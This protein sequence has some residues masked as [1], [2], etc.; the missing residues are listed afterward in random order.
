VSFDRYAEL[1]KCAAKALNPPESANRITMLASAQYCH[2]GLVARMAAGKTVNVS[3]VCKTIEILDKQAP[4]APGPNVTI[5]LV[6][7]NGKPRLT[8]HSENPASRQPRQ[9]EPD[10]EEAEGQEE[11]KARGRS[12]R[13]SR[14]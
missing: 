9:P 7:R 4:P 14:H 2:E 5:K 1:L 3:D 12:S 6:D 8:G 10:V 13:K 11:A